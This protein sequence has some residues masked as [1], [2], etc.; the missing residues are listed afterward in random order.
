M[1]EVFVWSALWAVVGIVLLVRLNGTDRAL[2]APILNFGEGVKNL[3]REEVCGLI[4]VYSRHAS[5]SFA[6]AAASMSLGILLAGV[7]LLACLFRNVGPG[8]LSLG[9]GG[10]LVHL[11]VARGAG[12]LYKLANAQVLSLTKLIT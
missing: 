2:L 7:T 4:P 11:I 5:R 3:R 8:S 10:V 9:S 12:N 1:T 6:L